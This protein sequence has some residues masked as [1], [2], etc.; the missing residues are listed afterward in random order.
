[1]EYNPDIHHRRSVR[2][3]GYDYSRA[4]AYF[5]TI[6]AWNRECLFGCVENSTMA[7]TEY[8]KM[9]EN[10]W[11]K[12][13]QMRPNVELD[14]FVVMPNHFHGIIQINDIREGE[15][16][17]QEGVYQ[18]APTIRSPSQTAGAIVRGFKSAVTKQINVCR[19]TPYADVLQRNYYEHIVRSDNELNTIREYIQNNPSTWI[20]DKLYP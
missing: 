3:K 18:Y 9:L 7:L 2:L 19:N 13:P 20:R 8:G 11:L 6:C 1:M 15:S 5:I 16:H 14:A 12:T 17:T 10:E 4:N